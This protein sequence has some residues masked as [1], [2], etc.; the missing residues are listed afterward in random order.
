M[1]SQK[2]I[3]EIQE[4]IERGQQGLNVGLPMGFDRLGHHTHNLQP[5]TYYLIAGATGSGKTAMVDTAFMSNPYN[6]ILTNPN[7]IYDL[8]I[9]YFSLEIE[10]TQKIAKLMANK[11]KQDYDIQTEVSE[12]YSKGSRKIPAIVAE[13]IKDIAPYFNDM[14]KKVFYKSAGSPDYVYK[15]VMEY[16][17]TRGEII[18]EPGSNKKIITGFI[19]I[20]PML[21]TLI[22][23]DHI[24]LIKP[25]KSD[26][27]LKNAIDRLSKTL[28]HFRNVFKFSP[29]V[30]SQFN[31]SIEAHDRMKDGNEPKLSDLKDSGG[32]SEDANLVMGLYYPYRY[33]LQSHQ[34]YDMMI[35]TNKYRSLHILKNRD[36]EDGLTIGLLFDG[37]N[38]YFEEMP[39]LVDLEL[40]IWNYDQ[41]LK[42]VSS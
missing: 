25:N 26:A 7:C 34:G 40:G 3:K 6:H 24:G 14:N 19:P 13:K 21:I 32:P 16:A 10:P 36:G 17:D 33:G 31:R 23:I 29:V 18:Y 30:V 41:I 4:T 28:V 9:I 42:K 1:E 38:G 39:T 20:N 35:M 37:R 11:L 27:T 8:E 12:I 5:A 15:E 2:Y 22:I